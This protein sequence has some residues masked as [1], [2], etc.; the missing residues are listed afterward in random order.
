[1]NDLSHLLKNNRAWA[2]GRTLTVHG[3]IYGI[4]DGLIRDLGMSV[5]QAEDLQAR[6]ASAVGV[7][8]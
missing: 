4:Q 7:A 5:A 8:E 1:M 6:Y 3:W 2:R